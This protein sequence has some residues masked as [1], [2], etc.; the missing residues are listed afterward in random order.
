[1]V[2]HDWKEYIYLQEN[3]QNYR[4]RC[5]IVSFC[6]QPQD[7]HHI[8]KYLQSRNVII[9][10]F[11]PLITTHSVHFFLSIF[12]WDTNINKHLCITIVNIGSTLQLLLPHTILLIFHICRKLEKKI[13]ITQCLKIMYKTMKNM[14]TDDRLPSEAEVDVVADSDTDSL[15]DRL[16][17]PGEY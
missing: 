3:P 13:G 14:Y 17:N 8:V 4:C 12:A 6:S 11:R 5:V 7:H 15:P 16:I 9:Y 10:E 2:V 1:M